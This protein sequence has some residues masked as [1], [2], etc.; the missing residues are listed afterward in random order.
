MGVETNGAKP[1]PENIEAVQMYK[2]GKTIQEIANKQQRTPKVVLAALKRAEKRGEDLELRKLKDY[3]FDTERRKAA[4]S[5]GAFSKLLKKET[6]PAVQQWLVNKV[7]T[8]K[9]DTINHYLIDLI[10]DAYFEETA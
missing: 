2:E 7:S 8:E 1:K 9:Y 4:V 5:I 10:V 3:N 6:D